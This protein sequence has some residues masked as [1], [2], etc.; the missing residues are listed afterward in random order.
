MRP[1]QEPQSGEAQ[2]LRIELPMAG[3]GAPRI[4][5]P[6]AELPWLPPA[7]LVAGHVA[8]GASWV[9]LIAL[10]AN[11]KALNSV[12]AFA[13]P[14]MAGM[15]WLTVLSL[16][17]L[18]H[19]IPGFLDVRIPAERFARFNVMV[20]WVGGVMLA[21]SFWAERTAWLPWAGAVAIAGILGAALPIA[22]GILAHRPASQERDKPAPLV[23][24]FGFVLVFLAVAAAFGGYLALVLAGRAPGNWFA[25]VLPAHA[26]LAVGGWL[27]LLVFGVSTRTLRRILGAPAGS[28][29]GLASAVFTAGIVILGVAWL[30]P[31]PWATWTGGG[32]AA[33]G[34][35]VFA[36]ETLKRVALARGSHQPPRAF[37]GASAAYLA[38]AALLGLGTM[39][40]M[41]L[42]HA[43][44]FVAIAGWVGQ[45]LSGHMLHMGTRF[46]LTVVRGPDDETEPEEVLSQSL[47][48][49]AF[50]LLQAAVLTG[51]AAGMTLRSDV[52]A[53]AGLLGLAGWTVYT[54]NYFLA[55]RRARTR[56]H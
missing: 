14:H 39:A 45:M 12:A 23:P 26:H 47:S 27:S 36:F 5:E 28:R 22:V 8:H 49:T 32:L 9:L 1:D 20:T 6:A 16:A 4:A 18:F 51:T 2:P 38:L 56:S 24:A 44:V 42:G 17:V 15:A 37:A 10:W 13:W 55:W 52:A 25:L 31:G 29:H 53:V 54:A 19:V 43:Y 46:L 33:I 50:G 30:L 35:F 40:G 48:W 34:A 7:A 11:G 3:P 41:P 21:G